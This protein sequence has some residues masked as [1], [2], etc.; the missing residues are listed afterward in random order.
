MKTVGQF[1]AFLGNRDQHIGADRYPDLC[2]DSVLAGAKK[3][4]D[5]KVLFDPFEEQLDLPS[6]SIWT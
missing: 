1:Q 5:T 3:R 4:L 6:L 2:L